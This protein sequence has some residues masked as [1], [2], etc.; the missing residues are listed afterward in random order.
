MAKFTKQKSGLYRTTI[1]IGYKDNGLPLK[2]YLSAP[3]IKELEAKILEAKNDINGGLLIG[4]N[5]LFGRYADKWLTV[6]KNS[7]S[8]QTQNMYKNA[9]K[10]LSELSSVPVK[11]ITRSMV[12]EQINANSDHPRVCEIMLLTLKQIFKSAQDDGLLGK[13]PCSGIE[14]PRH[15]KNEKRALTDE[16]KQKLRSAVLPPQERLLL[17]L[18]YG[19]GCRPA[20]VYA[21]TKADFDF[22]NGTISISKSVQFDNNSVY[23][24]SAPKTNSSIRSVIVSEPI[25]RGLKHIIDK[26]PTDNVLGGENG[27]IMNKTKYR[28]MFNHILEKAGLKNSGISQYTFR[29]NFVTECYYNDVS[30]KECQRQM[31]HKDYK[32]ILEVYSHL[33]AKKE[34]TKEKLSA[35]MM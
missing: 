33:D 29:H 2:K 17:L 31:G 19:T 26:I 7:K 5:T 23:S 13:N 11:K 20:E 4:D 3:T 1:Q 25:L 9:V 16:E 18:L 15:V 14:L 12:Q 30:L 6:Y 35:M 8:I 22:K 32:M 34:N 24:V 21:L 10:H 28:T 27:Q